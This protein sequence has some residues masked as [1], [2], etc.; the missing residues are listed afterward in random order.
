MLIV[1]V[2]Y[3]ACKALWVGSLPFHSVQRL[4]P[5][6][7]DQQF[8]PRIVSWLLVMLKLL[9]QFLFIFVYSLNR[10]KSRKR[11]NITFSG[12]GEIH[13]SAFASAVTKSFNVIPVGVESGCPLLSPRC[14]RTYVPHRIRGT[15]RTTP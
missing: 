9:R 4:N 7:T 12:P 5:N 1:G 14:L 15:I 11:V 8:C 13:L 2:I 10:R 6:Y 3:S